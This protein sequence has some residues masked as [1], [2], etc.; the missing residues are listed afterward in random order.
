MDY[1]AVADELSPDLLGAILDA[2]PDRGDY[3]V[4]AYSVVCTE[5]RR[6]GLAW[7]CEGKTFLTENGM[8]IRSRAPANLPQSN[9]TSK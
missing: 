7:R 4:D 9:E 3:R 8:I 2:K 5:L 1:D 6:L